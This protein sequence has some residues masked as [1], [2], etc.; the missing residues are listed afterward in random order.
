MADFLAVI[1]LAVS[2]L[3]IFAWYRVICKMG[4]PGWYIVLFLIPIAGPFFFLYL[5][6]AEWP[7]EKTLS[8]AQI[9]VRM[10]ER[11]NQSSADAPAEAP[12]F[13]GRVI[14]GPAA[15]DAPEPMPQEH[16]P[17]TGDTAGR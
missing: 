11:A 7:I 14:N 6:F 5:A 17:R 8:D 9:Q 16:Q 4:F 12:S 13:A 15:H 3:M 2:V 10:F 1:V